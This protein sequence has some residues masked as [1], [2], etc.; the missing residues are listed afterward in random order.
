MEPRS[1]LLDFFDASKKSSTHRDGLLPITPNA[2]KKFKMMCMHNPGIYGSKFNFEE[3][4]TD[5]GAE[6]FWEYFDGRKYDMVGVACH[7]VADQLSKIQ[8]FSD[9]GFEIMDDLRWLYFAFLRWGDWFRFKSE[10]FQMIRVIVNFTALWIPKLKPEPS[11]EVVSFDLNKYRLPDASEWNKAKDELMAVCDANVSVSD[12]SKIFKSQ[13]QKSAGFA[14]SPDQGTTSL[15]I[16]FGN[17]SMASLI[18]EFVV[19]LMTGDDQRLREVVP[20]ASGVQLVVE[21][22][23]TLDRHFKMGTVAFNDGPSMMIGMKKVLILLA[24]RGAPELLERFLHCHVLQ[25]ECTNVSQFTCTHTELL[26]FRFSFDAKPAFEE[27]ITS[28][29]PFGFCP[30]CVMRSMDRDGSSIKES[31]DIDM[32]MNTVVDELKKGNQGVD[33]E[34]IDEFVKLGLLMVPTDE[35]IINGEN[36]TAL[37]KRFPCTIRRDHILMPCMDFNRLQSPNRSKRVIRLTPRPQVQ[38]DEVEMEIGINDTDHVDVQGPNFG[39]YLNNLLELS[40]GGGFMTRVKNPKLGFTAAVFQAIV[41]MQPERF[42]KRRQDEDEDEDDADDEDKKRPRMDFVAF[43]ETEVKKHQIE[44]A[45]ERILKC[46]VESVDHCESLDEV[47]HAHPN[48]FESAI[49]KMQDLKSTR[50]WLRHTTHFGGKKNS[51]AQIQDPFPDNESGTTT[52]TTAI[53]YFDNDRNDYEIPLKFQ[54]C[55]CTFM[56]FFLEGVI[57]TALLDHLGDKAYIYGHRYFEWDIKHFEQFLRNSKN[58]INVNVLIYKK[59]DEIKR[60]IQ[61]N[62]FRDLIED[63][64]KNWTINPHKHISCWM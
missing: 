11:I 52:T 45:D 47:L 10:I 59:N 55:S 3:I 31:M 58:V 38:R 32:E 60:E 12:F 56:I 27:V 33:E 18:D 9:D 35:P 39:K 21:M 37:T 63:S 30:Q 2:M 29:E 36:C 14:V 44:P 4:P 15:K 34:T 7:M 17:V 23:T 42:L 48:S 16:D 1:K 57:C 8:S 54:Q 13:R 40:Q 19:S 24:C 26:S 25:L 5:D 61:G 64:A 62:P 46:V 51:T 22:F 28:N 49:K 50:S 43:R 53:L 20:M 41:S 6:R